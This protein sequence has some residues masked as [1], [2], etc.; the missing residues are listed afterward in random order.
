MDEIPN[1]FINLIIAG[2]PYNIGTK[3]GEFNDSL[4]HKNYIFLMNKIFSECFRVL[5]LDGR[6][7]IEVADSVYIGGNYIQLAGLIQKICLDIGF[8]LESRHISFVRVK[9]HIEIPEHDWKQDYTTKKNAHSNCHQYLILT[10]KKV[11]WKDGTMFYT[12]YISKEGHPC[13]F[14]KETTDFILKKYFNKGCSVLDPFM[15]TASLGVEVLK[16]GGVF[17]GYEVVKDFYKTASKKLGS[18]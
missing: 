1:N 5:R 16:R 17:Y 9:N 12:N 6:M 3:Y 13:P 11:G 15:G 18:F 8:N 14:P 10:K 2:P 7:I 4:S